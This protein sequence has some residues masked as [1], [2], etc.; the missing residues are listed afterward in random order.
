MVRNPH[1]G[2]M[3]ADPFAAKAASMKKESSMREHTNLVKN[4]RRLLETEVSQAEV[5]MAA[6]K[7]SEELQEMVEKIGR[8][9]NE[10]LP[11][12][13]GQMRETYGMESA[14]AFQTQIYGSFQGVMDSLYTA[15]SQVDDAVANLA[16]TGQIGAAVD[17]DKDMGMASDMGMD[18]ADMGMD[19]AD[20]GDADLDL[21][22]IGD[23]LGADD[24]FGGAEG[25][26]PLGR[27]M[28]TE[29]ALQ[30]KVLEMQKLVTKARKLKE[31][32]K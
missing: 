7:F 5:M 22:N 2:E 8:L 29:A 31:A 27:A 12:V 18:D 24:E 9:Q 6:K 11:P 19:D 13:T 32:R 17:M 10:D 25:E 20:M 14:S 23:E 26:E 30:R 15:K 1:T 21:D 4:L 3:Q 28:K 16:T